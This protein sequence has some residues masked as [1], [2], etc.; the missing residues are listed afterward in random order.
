M[1]FVTVD[2]VLRL[3]E[4]EG[5][6]LAGLDFGLLESAVF[7]PQASAGGDDAYPGVHLKAAALLHSLIG[8]HPF[9]DGNKRTGWLSVVEFYALNGY[10]MTAT[11]D[12]VVDMVRAVARGELS[13]EEI[14]A[15][16]D[17]GTVYEIGGPIP[18]DDDAA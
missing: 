10:G 12:D 16:L 14:A 17:G 13:V 3:H 11:N 2:D 8:N 9:V 5:G 6:G 7:R 18:E 4:A 1:R 15:W